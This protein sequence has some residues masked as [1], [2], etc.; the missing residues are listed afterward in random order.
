MGAF[1]KRFAAVIVLSGL[2]GSVA[3]PALAA[4]PGSVCPKVGQTLISG[5]KLYTCIKSGSKLVWNAGKPVSAVLA[6]TP[7]PTISGS[8]TVDETLFANT[9]VW[10]SGVQLSYQWLAGGTPI[11]GANDRTY[12]P[13]TSDV[14][15][16][17]SVRVTGQKAGVKPA[18]KVSAATSTV[19][20]PT[21]ATPVSQSLKVLTA[22]SVPKITGSPKVGG[23]L[24][25]VVGKWDSGVTFRYQWIRN[26]IAISGAN[27]FSYVP[28][29]DD[30]ATFITLAVTGTKNGY[31]PVT[32]VSDVALITTSINV[33]PS[34]S[35]PQ[36]EGS[37]VVGSTLSASVSDWGVSGIKYVYQWTRNGSNISGAVGASYKLA[38]SDLNAFVGVTVTGSKP[39]YLTET[40]PNLGVGPVQNANSTPLLAF[41]TASDPEVSG[42]LSPGSV[43]SESHNSWSEG[44]TYALQWYRSGLPIAGA[45]SANYTVLASDVGKQISVTLTGSKAGYISQS[46]VRFVGIVTASTF[47]NA[48]TPSI[49]GLARD[50]AT[51]SL[52]SG[53][54]NWSSPAT[55]SIQWL[56]NGLA[57]GGATGTS[58]TLNSG[59]IGSVFTVSVTGA[60]AGYTTMTKV[61]APTSVVTA[62]TIAGSKPTIIGT[63]QV[64][65]TLTAVPGY[66]ESGVSLSFQWLR[67]G[68]PISGATSSTYTLVT[69]DN[70]T[71]VSVEVT[72]SKVGL[73]NLVQT[74]SATSVTTT[75]LTLTPTP[76]VT[77]V[78]QVSQTLAANAGSWDSGVTVRY[79]WNR[80]GVAISGATSTTY[81]IAGADL[82]QSITVSVTGTKPGYTTVIKTSAP[83][84][85][86]AGTFTSSPT[87]TISGLAKL[88]QTLSVSAGSWDSGALL[89]YQWLADGAPI[90]GATSTTL[91]LI[92]GQIGKT[93]SVSVTAT[94]IGVTA[95]TKTSTPTSAVVADSFL[96]QPIPTISGSAMVGKALTL[97][98]GTWDAGTVLAYQWKRGGTSISGA[99]SATYTLVSADLSAIISVDVKATKSGNLPLTKTSANVGPVV[100]AAILVQG[101]PTLAGYAAVGELISADRGVWESGLTYNYQWKRNGASIAG[102][103]TLT[104]RVAPIDLGAILTLAVTASNS[105]A[106]ATKSSNPSTPVVK[107]NLGAAANAS[108]S[109]TLRV[110]SVLSSSQVGWAPTPS[111]TYQWQRNGAPIAGATASTYSVKS[112]DLD[113]TISIG[114]TGVLAGYNDKTVTA[115]ASS[116]ILAGLISPAP[117]PS[118]VGGLRIG[119]TLSVST[120]SWMTGTTLTYQWLKSSSPIAGATGST[121]TVLNTDI[122]SDISVTVTGAAEG[123]DTSSQTSPKV[124]VLTPAQAPVIYSTL[125][126]TS[127]FEVNWA[128]RLYTSY[129]FTAKNSSG[130]VVGQ[131][132]CSTAC[133]SP[134]AITNLPE[135]T[136]STS[137]TLEYTA[138]TDGGTY[139][140]T[141]SASTYPKMTLNVTVNSIYQTGN[142]YVINFQAIPGWTYQFRNYGV[143]DNSNCGVVG[144][145]YTTSPMT[146]WLP[147]GLC[148][149]EFV[150]EDGHGNKS[151]ATVSSSYV[152]QNPIPAPSL[153][154][155]I[156][157]ST[158]TSAESISYSATYSSYG[159]YY[160]YK[161]VILDASGNAVTPAVSPTAQRVGGLQSGTTTGTLYFLGL[162][163]GTYTIR[164]DFEATNDIRYGSRKASAI[165]GTVTVTG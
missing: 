107:G 34:V 45:T 161:P 135:S 55:T 14:G 48:P 140:G 29:M 4:I 138:T 71:S 82:N 1:F 56:K 64:G 126:K 147:R 77:G 42:T 79:Q 28:T 157:A 91:K 164:M 11:A 128:W 25:A 85:V 137:Y 12:V 62:A 133:V 67:N 156:S 130:A 32:Q 35:M 84:T 27:G 38:A 165:I 154:G 112:A 90:S 115:S 83:V 43:L 47:A 159:N 70:A 111:F 63:S 52:G 9:G 106:T 21:V 99:T 152:I 96:S 131:Y 149:V 89:A 146:L 23:A 3:T 15:R 10:D 7:T 94:K 86:L 125:S 134:L 88:D 158:V 57:V 61:S 144:P 108:I 98:T 54:L 116:V 13:A 37:P 16:R 74:S 143:Y 109:G 142:E 119:D 113:S 75:I 17:V 81:L 153:S 72:G 60:A 105:F 53:S 97:S 162:A 120:G 51:L 46:R 6:K 40:R 22:S 141:I 18:S 118:V 33:F 132:S 20:P 121:Y 101:N 31:R 104:Y 41:L 150:I 68:S 76:T 102:A 100:A 24:T 65:S 49:E 59:D 123:Y 5:G 95:T 110:G 145:V 136:S 87:P 148:S 58:L 66:W 2:L 139:S 103:T 92:A 160:S 36:V 122:Y 50:G 19:K 39:G 26:N 155:S 69:E 127:R 114:V 93:I 30:A 44:V 80:G 151:N 117:T 78:P 8:P 73:P 129:S 124:R 163:A